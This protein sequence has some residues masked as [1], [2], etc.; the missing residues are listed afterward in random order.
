MRALGVNIKVKTHS[1]VVK[2][3]NNHL[4]LKTLEGIQLIQKD[5]AKNNL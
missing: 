2:I 3:L 5:H 1:E 4:D